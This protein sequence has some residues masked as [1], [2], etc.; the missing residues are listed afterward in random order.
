LQTNYR[1]AINITDHLF[2]DA[3]KHLTDFYRTISAVE[4]KY[5]R[6]KGGNA[7]I[8]ERFD[9]CMDDDFNT[10]LALSDLF[11]LFKK[12]AAKLAAGD[13]SCADDV[14]QIKKTY[15]LLGLFKKDAAEYLAEVES[16]APKGD[17]PAE[18][19]ELAAK[20]WQAKK[21]KNW[22]EADSLRAQ[23]DALGYIVKDSK[24][25]YDIIKK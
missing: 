6:S 14:A 7:E 21:D 11:A 3:E 19:E 20:R 22:A 12:V 16:K 15:S 1:N 18:V 9:K 4:S 10:A 23:I 24:D 2:P 8:D 13:S 25:G 5:G 17:I